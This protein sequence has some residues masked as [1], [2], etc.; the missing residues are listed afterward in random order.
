MVLAAMIV[1]SGFGLLYFAV[2]NEERQMEEADR[3][4]KR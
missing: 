2:M 3:A 1:L 4:H